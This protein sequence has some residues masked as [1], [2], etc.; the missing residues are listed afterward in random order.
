MINHRKD[1]I[2]HRKDFIVRYYKN[3]S[4]E[5]DLIILKQ[6]IYGY[7]NGSHQFT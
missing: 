1:F 6:E 2:N 5:F 3:S 4:N 7:K